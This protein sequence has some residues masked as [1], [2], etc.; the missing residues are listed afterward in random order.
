MFGALVVRIQQGLE[1]QLPGV[2]CMGRAV[3]LKLLGG[4]GFTAQGLEA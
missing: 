4:A 1:F 2:E 3:E